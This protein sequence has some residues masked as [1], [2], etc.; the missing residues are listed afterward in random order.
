MT[1]TEV[2]ASI[3]RRFEK[4][5]DEPDT[6]SEDFIVRLDYVNRAIRQWEN[7]MGMDWKELYRTLSGTLTSGVLTGSTID[8]LKSP[9][10][11]VRIGTD[12]YEYVRPERVE[13]EVSLYSSKKIYTITGAKEAKSINVYPVVSDDFYL[14]Y[15]KYATIYST[16]E[17][18][19]EIEMSNPEFI[20]QFVCAQL[21]LDDANN[22]QA[23]VEMQ[24]ATD[25]MNSMKLNNEKL[26]FWQ[27]DNQGS[28]EGINFGQ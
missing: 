8:A 2:M 13:R 18:T 6:T 4:S 21:Y 7:E 28:N 20:I 3:Y 14:D 26:P 17:E 27:E 22:T 11:F 19:G 10:G 1:I 24:G 15:Q 23:G 9:S 12:R 5:S 16:G 25:A